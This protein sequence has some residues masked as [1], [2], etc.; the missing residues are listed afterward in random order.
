MHHRACCIIHGPRATKYIHGF[1]EYVVVYETGVHWKEAHEQY[2]VT[3]G[4]EDVPDFVIDSFFLERIFT[5]HHVEAKEG[6]Y[7]TMTRI[8]EHYCE[9]EGES[10]DC[11]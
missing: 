4:E 11:V 8:A 1:R 5:N 7:H 6:H 2:D 10:N 3:T 9:Q